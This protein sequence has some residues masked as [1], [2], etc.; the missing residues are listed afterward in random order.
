MRELFLL[1]PEIVFL[2][3]GSFGACPRPV[4]AEY[5]RFQL[6][7]EREPVEFLGLKRRFPELIGVARERLAAYVGA[8][9][10]DLVLVPNATTAVNAVARSLDLQPGDEIVATTHEYGGN[11]LLWRYICER[12]RCALGGRHDAHKRRGR[13]ARRRHA[14]NARAVRQSHRFSD[15]ASLSRRRAVREAREAGVLDRRRRARARPDRARPA[16]LGADFYAGN[17]HKVALLAEGAGF[18]HVRAEAQPMLEPRTVSWD[19]A[20]DEWANPPPLGRHAT[21][22]APRG[23]GGDRLPGRARWDAVRSDATDLRARRASSPRFGMEPLAK[24]TTSSCRWSLYAAA[25][26][27]GRPRQASLPRTA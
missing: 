6:E 14:A 27:R 4:F 21:R 11:D 9:A 3:H 1:D 20:A 26:R 2:N 17:C 18:L 5:Q 12:R 10:S 25:R 23:P 8:S 22:R 19:W 16:S 13:P 24:T 7:L 15:V